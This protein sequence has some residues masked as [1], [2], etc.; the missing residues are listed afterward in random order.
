MSSWAALRA[1]RLAEPGAMTKYDAVDVLIAET[2]NRGPRF[3][4]DQLIGRN[5][6]ISAP[7]LATFDQRRD[8]RRANPPLDCARE[9]KD[10]DENRA[11]N[12]QTERRHPSE[13]D[14]CK[15]HDKDHDRSS[16]GAFE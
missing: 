13:G 5:E 6:Q 11:C 16:C 8:I 4:A 10:R 2:S 15:R 14:A 3:P 1:R 12:A 7:R 9:G